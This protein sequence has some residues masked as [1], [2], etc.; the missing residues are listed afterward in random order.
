MSFLSIRELLP[1]TPKNDS[2]PRK[3]EWLKSKWLSNKWEVLDPTSLTEWGHTESLNF[4]S[5][6]KKNTAFQDKPEIVEDI[7]RSLAFSVEVTALGSALGQPITS[8][9][10]MRTRVNCLK[11]IYRELSD[12]GFDN[13]SDIDQKGVEVLRKRLSVPE[14]VS[15]NYEE[16]IAEY[17]E[18]IE[19][20]SIPYKD[21]DKGR[22]LQL[23][24]NAIY[25]ELGLDPYVGR[26]SAKIRSLFHSTEKML[27]VVH[28]AKF[29]QYEETLEEEYLA[30]KSYA[31]QYT[32]ILVTLETMYRQSEMGDM[33]NFPLLVDPLSNHDKEHWVSLYVGAQSASNRTRNIPV[34]AWMTLMDA[35][36]R[37]VVDYA[38]PLKQAEIE[39]KKYFQDV[40]ERQDR[41]TAGKKTGLF[42]RER[43]YAEGLHSPFPL[44]AYAQYQEREDTVWTNEKLDAIN[45]DLNAGMPSKEIQKKWGIT[46]SQIQF[47][48]NKLAD[49][50]SSKGT[51]LSLHR[52]RYNFLPLCCTLILLAFTAGRESS[53]LSLRKGCIRRKFGDLYINMYIPKT[54]RSN[55]ELPTVEIVE[56][57]IR[58][59]EEVSE[60]ARAE[61]GS[62]LLYQFKGLMDIGISGFHW[63]NV[64]DDFVEWIG[65]DV[66]KD[67]Q[68]FDFSEHQFRRFFAMMYFYRYDSKYKVNALMRFMRHLD[69]SMT[70]VYITERTAGLV[71]K[72]V[73]DERAAEFAIAA[74]TGEAGGGMAKEFKKMLPITF[75]VRTQKQQDLMLSKINEG[76]F[77]WNFCADGVCFGRTPGREELSHCKLVS[78][79][80]VYVMI[81]KQ[82]QG[83][84][85]GC[86]NLLTME[87]I[88][89]DKFKE[90]RTTTTTPGLKAAL[91]ASQ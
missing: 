37:W 83:D 18:D 47:A 52:A 50:S 54:L 77:V 35:A 71:L 42:L 31:K 64:I 58:V 91:G 2:F 57:A 84:C 60:E 4:G 79:G 86:E 8:L 51:K 23:N 17:L 78:E 59:L 82:E 45:V 41:H 62:D 20:L 38:E 55:D 53:I 75:R 9:K 72:E 70:L 39:S 32:D 13:L 46:R 12:L 6:L 89:W 14:I 10:I 27:S 44:S 67:G 11:R 16:K 63:N 30:G 49:R 3:F 81:H 68:P 29:V 33:F 74:N 15:R 43:V 24:R 87:E 28:G 19:P 22:G 61:S 66:E 26:C 1:K 36:V 90:P 80:Q 76:S 5:V 40:E 7:K 25:F 34:D 65:L 88:K 73:A 56:M 48:S 85:R 21:L 69:W